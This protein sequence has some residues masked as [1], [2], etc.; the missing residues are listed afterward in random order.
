[1]KGFL[2]DTNVIAMLSPQR[3]AAPA[4][5]RDWIATTAAQDRLF[6]S[7]VTIHEIEKGI[8]LLENKGATARAASLRAWL[9]GLAAMYGERV[10][11]VDVH[12]AMV[13]GRLEARAVSAGFSPGASDA[14]I[15]GTAE[16][17]NLIVVTANTRHFAPF[18]I[19]MTSPV[20]VVAEM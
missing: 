15:A 9:D 10:L 8:A 2:L 20:E 1:V 7:A 14:M 16:A 12:V 5:F 6:L 11:P 18:G 3:G 4:R 19:A 17:N 13:S